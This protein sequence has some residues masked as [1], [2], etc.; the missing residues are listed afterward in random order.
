MTEKKKSGIT[1]SIIVA[2]ILA[3]VVAASVL[4]YWTQTSE[5]TG[6]KYATEGVVVLDNS[7]GIHDELM[8]EGAIA[9]EFKN[10]AY[11]VDGKIFKCYVGN[12]SINEYDMFLTI[13]A[14]KEMTDQICM[15][16]MITPGNAFEVL[17]LDRA[18][19]PGDHM[20]Y[21]AYT[22]MSD[23]KTIHAQTLHTM[24]FHVKEHS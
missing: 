2:V 18:L 3:V 4:Y 5:D 22:Q 13:Y 15:T 11:S 14:D 20:V 1:K 19:E 24:D 16:G 8:D 7:D 10:D 6:M 21:V 17:E 9:L 12:S 23:P